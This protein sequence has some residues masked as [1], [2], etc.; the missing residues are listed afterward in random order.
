MSYL[1][2]FKTILELKRY[3]KSTLSVYVNFLKL[4]KEAYN[5]SD[6]NL[7]NLKDRD[8]LNSIVA[9]VRNKK[10]SISSQKQLI[11]AISLFYRELFKRS[12]DFSLIYP[13]RKV[14]GLPIVLSKEEVK[15]MLKTVS[16]LKHKT[17]L[18]S[19]YGLGLRISEVINLKIVDVDSD[20]MLVT[21]KEGKGNK[22]R[23]VMLPKKL[24]LLFREYFLKYR[25]KEYLFE[26]QSL[27]KYSASSIRKVFKKSLK[28]ANITKNAT[29]HTLRHSFAT[30]LL[31]NGTD[32]RII[33]KLLGH[34]NIATTLIYTKV[35][36]SSIQ[37]VESPLDLL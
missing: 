36:K 12:I 9:L 1:Y 23:I 20:R 37:N 24:L 16:N 7:E 25:P 17:I 22:D 5:Y 15:T 30:H 26:G 28:D 35:S 2:S 18:A 27:S 4:F 32:I 19:V 33:Q 31:E 6:K 14:E 29:V 11:G 8:V 3:S 10:Y 13:S 21:I 34:K